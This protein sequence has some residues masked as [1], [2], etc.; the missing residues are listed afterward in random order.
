MLLDPKSKLVWED[1]PKPANTFTTRSAIM[2]D[3]NASK[4]V[5]YYSANT[6][7]VVVQKCVTEKGS[8][9]RTASARENSLNWAFE[10]TALGLPNEIAPSVPTSS[11]KVKPK[12][13]HSHTTSGTKKQKPVQN[14][15]TPQDGEAK[16]NISWLKRLFKRK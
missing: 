4:A 15:P 9:Y 8:F 13:A 6:K 1:L 10:A 14:A 16:E 12:P 11:P 3:L 5:Q 2:Y 7:I